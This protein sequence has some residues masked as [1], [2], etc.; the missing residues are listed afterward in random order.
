MNRVASKFGWVQGILSAGTLG[1]IVLALGCPGGTAPPPA[2]DI[3]FPADYRESFTIVRDCRNSVEHTSYIRVWVN[4][5]GA[6][7]Y[8]TDA[9]T[10]PEGTIVVKEEF[11]A[12]TCDNDDDLEFWSVMRKEPAGFDLGAN[13][14]RFQEVSGP[15]RQITLDDNATCIGCH[16]AQACI[17]RDLMCTV[18]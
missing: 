11:A 13:D 8:L 18:P 5:I 6:A 1:M 9:G 2:A 17:P 12:N 7:E 16:T 3:I 15:N 10:L 14:W 4:Q